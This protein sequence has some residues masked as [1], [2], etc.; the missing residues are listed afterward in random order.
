LCVAAEEL[1]A[2]MFALL[3]TDEA[4]EAEF[5]DPFGERRSGY[6]PAEGAV[7][8]VLE[9]RSAAKLRGQRVLAS[10]RG[11]ASISALSS[12]RIPGLL[13]DGLADAQVRPDELGCVMASGN[14]S[15]Q[16]AAEA[17][18]VAQV[19]GSQVPVTS[20]KGAFGECGAPSA[21][22]SA[23]ALM[24]CSRRALCPPTVGRSSYDPSLPA[25]DLLREPVRMRTPFALINAVNSDLACAALV[26]E[27]A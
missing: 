26:L 8:C 22:L 6:V 25:L 18:A 27:L 20:V 2:E 9:T 15:L 17:E 19:C 11:Y 21:L 1:S 23:A 16:D 7:A 24:I 3:K 13:R 5:P 14:G 12:K 10:C 4:L